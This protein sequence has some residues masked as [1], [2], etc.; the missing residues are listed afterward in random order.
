MQRNIPDL[1]E[2]LGVEKNA[3][4]AQIKKAFRALTYHKGRVGWHEIMYLIN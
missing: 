2:I 4:T 1:Y 3:T